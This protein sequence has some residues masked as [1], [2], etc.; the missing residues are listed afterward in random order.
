MSYRRP[1]ASSEPAFNPLKNRWLIAIVIAGVLTPFAACGGGGAPP[2]PSPTATATAPGS[3][4]TARKDDPR[5]KYL[6]ITLVLADGAAQTQ[7][8]LRRTEG[9]EIA[10]EG[11]LELTE[12]SDLVYRV[13]LRDDAQGSYFSQDVLSLHDL[14]SA[15]RFERAVS[16]PADARLMRVVF[17]PVDGPEG[18]STI[19]YHI[20]LAASEIG[21]ASILAPATND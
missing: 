17:E 6:P 16:V 11:E 21:T 5:L 18:A 7:V 14:S 2:E 19:E 3:L 15:G 9:G 13:G 1:R 8:G 20:D 4:L 10:V 12:P